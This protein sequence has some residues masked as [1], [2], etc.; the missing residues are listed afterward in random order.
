[1]LII[2]LSDTNSKSCPLYRAIQ[3]E[4]GSVQGHR[5]VSRIHK[6]VNINGLSLCTNDDTGEDL[7]TGNC[8]GIN[9]CVV[10]LTIHTR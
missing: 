7:A 5:V 6:T 10:E 4:G 2:V 8:S 3:G 1:V 9:S